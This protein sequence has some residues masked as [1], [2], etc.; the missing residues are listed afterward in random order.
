MTGRDQWTSSNYQD[1]E[2]DAVY[3]C[4]GPM[5]GQRCLF[6]DSRPRASGSSSFPTASRGT[7]RTRASMLKYFE[8]VAVNRGYQVKAFVVEQEVMVWLQGSP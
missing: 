5:A 6:S 4:V 1:N 8:D 7:R 3:A 2:S